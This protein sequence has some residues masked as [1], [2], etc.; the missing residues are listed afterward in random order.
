MESNEEKFSLGEMIWVG[1]CSEG[2]ILRRSPI[3]VSELYAQYNPKPKTVNSQMYSD[4]IREQV[5][6][7]VLQRWALPIK[8]PI[9]DN[10]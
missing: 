7:T 10:R 1:V 2:L 9:I 3:F 8:V 5:G 4:M 6:P